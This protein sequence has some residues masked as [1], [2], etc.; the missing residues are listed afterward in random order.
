MYSRP[1][2]G[3][4]MLL[5]IIDLKAG[6]S[7]KEVLHGID[8]ELAEGEIVAL[9]GPNGAG[10]ST[11]L[12][13][14]TGLTR[15]TSGS[16]QFGG[17]DITA[18]ST[19]SLVKRGVVHCPEARELFPDMSV[20][21][22]LRLGSYAVRVAS[23]EQRRRLDH[24]Y[25]LFPKLLDRK[26]QLAGSLSGGEQQMVAIGRALMAEPRLL[27]L[28]EPSL[29][30]APLLVTQ[31]FELISRINEQGMSILLVEQ[32]A[33]ASL[34][35]AHRGYV[36]EAGRIVGHDDAEKLASD[37]RVREAYLGGV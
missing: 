12:R 16:V 19:A 7:G 3:R 29:G 21:E 2:W 36:I 11:T 4:T 34:D 33:V 1:I 28:D 6:Y 9:I 32:N 20:L 37:P 13:T 25:E 27:L 26:D 23:Q 24:V 35:I 10:K 18:R 14:I 17:D 8:L 22:N 5:K 31:M 15:A 30:L